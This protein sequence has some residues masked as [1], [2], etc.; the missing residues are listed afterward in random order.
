MLYGSI[1]PKDFKTGLTIAIDGQPN[2]IIEFQHV[3]Q[4][5]GAASTKTKFK[6]M[7]TGATLQ[8]TVQ[9]A[10][11]FD[12]AQIDR[13]DAQFTYAEGGNYYFM[14]METYEEKM[15]E[16]NVVDEYSD[17][18]MEGMTLK[19]VQYEGKVIDVN[20]PSTLDFEVVQTDPNV[21]GNSAQGVT[22]P[23]VLECGATIMA[24]MSRSK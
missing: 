18:I 14:D 8:K 7:I 12:P 19:L 22:K 5:R 10:E 4:A 16:G 23:A 15:A 6:N 11:S 20:L 13:S 9:A 24:Y 2:K 21:K 1:A 3:K 17:W